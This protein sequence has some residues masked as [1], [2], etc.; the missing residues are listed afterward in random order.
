M[1]TLVLKGLR[2]LLA[3]C[4]FVGVSLTLSLTRRTLASTLQAL[5]LICFGVMAL[6]HAFEA[7]AIFP[8]L[9]WGQ[10]HSVGHYVDLVA[11]LS[12]VAL[13]LAGFALRQR[14]VGRS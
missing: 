13:T 10:P 14:D 4:I 8:T 5:G 1:S 3:A 6:T 9:G 12:G 7:F 11:A 2:A